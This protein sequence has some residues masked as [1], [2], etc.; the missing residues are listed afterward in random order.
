MT[1][2]DTVNEVAGHRWIQVLSPVTMQPQ[3]GEAPGAGGEGGKEGSTQTGLA[4]CSLWV[5]LFPEVHIWEAS[6][7]R[8]LQ[9]SVNPG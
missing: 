1:E 7:M 2:C 9:G 4:A 6:L 5:Q 3:P 8:A